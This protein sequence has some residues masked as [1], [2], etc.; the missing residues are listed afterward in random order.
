MWSPGME[1]LLSERQARRSRT[2]NTRLVRRAYSYSINEICELFGIHSNTVRSWIRGGLEPIDGNRPTLI[3]G[4]ILTAFL[5]ERQSSR[6]RACRPGEFY[7]CSC[8]SPQRP[9]ERLVGV[10][11]LTP[12]RLLLKAV[13]GQCASRMNQLGSRSKWAKYEELFDIQTVT[14]RS[15]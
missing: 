8:R 2:Y 15:L 5:K 11:I 10:E 3:H 7:C 12:D 13:C 9:W 4:S 1:S 6:K 14:E